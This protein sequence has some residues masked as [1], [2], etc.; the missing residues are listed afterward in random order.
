MRWAVRMRFFS[1]IWLAWLLITPVLAG[2]EGLAGY[3][4][5]MY[6]PYCA[7]ACVRSL[8]S[9]TLNCSN[10]GVTLGM[11]TFSTSTECYASDTPYLT[12]LAWCAHTK[13][14]TYDVSAS[15]MEYF[16]DRQATGQKAAGVYAVPAKWTYAE[17][18]Q[19]VT[20]P[21]TLQLLPTDTALNST[22]LVPESVY[23]AQYNV[24]YSVQR[25][26]TQENTYG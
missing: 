22:A 6:D 20:E 2:D 19:H 10:G 17:A 3:P 25:E 15:K 26:S 21:P 11:V 18:L 16:W 13:C 7:T 1:A 4:A 8:S 23:Q 12:S 5:N 9:L 24:L 14:A